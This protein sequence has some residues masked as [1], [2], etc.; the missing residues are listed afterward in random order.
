MTG[1]TVLVAEDSE[2][3]RAVIRAQLQDQGYRVV[4]AVDGQDALRKCAAEPPDVVLLDVEMPVLDGYGVLRALKEDPVL[5]DIPVVFL[6]SRSRTEEVVE[7]LRLGAH[8]YLRKPIEQ[9]ELVGRIRAAVRVK[10][11]Q[12]ELRRRNEELDRISRVD[13]LTG[14]HNR[15]HVEEHLVA[16]E[17]T[18]RRHRQP[19]AVMI[20]DIDHFKKVNDTLGHA[21][22]DHVL[23]EVASRLA[24]AV[25]VED[26]L[27]RWG[28]EEFVAV[29]PNT[30]AAGA[31][32]LAERLRAAVADVPVLVSGGERAVTVSIG[33]ACC[34]GDDAEA[35]LRAA[36]AAL[37]EAK[38]G[39]RNRVVVAG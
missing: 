10:R 35:L 20:I 22:G 26:L 17:S 1:A 16:A 3:I 37:Y 38:E 19:L 30:D 31:G 8:D 28:G 18:Y 36:D 11:L 14:L 13:A 27:G 24:A 4:E 5:G 39:G 6:T 23:R 21:A 29:L 7:G 25:R 33:C 2:V 34:T 32:E 12:D 15:R 9:I